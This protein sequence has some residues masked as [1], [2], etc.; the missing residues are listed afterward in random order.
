MRRR[1]TF[2]LTILFLCINFYSLRGQTGPG[3]VGDVVNNRLWLSADSNVVAAASNVLNWLDLSGNANHATALAVGQEPNLIA[4]EING[5][6][7]I[8]FNDNG[9][10]NGDYLGANLSLGISGSGASTVF[11][12]AKNT[13]ASVEDNSGLFIGQASGAGGTVRHYGLEYNLAVRFNSS[14]LP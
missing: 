14:L 7:V 2:L 11:M 9:G 1:L 10:T 8:R 4:A 13:T 3:G 12:V 5:R 6:D